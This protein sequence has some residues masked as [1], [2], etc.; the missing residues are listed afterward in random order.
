MVYGTLK[1]IFLKNVSIY[2]TNLDKINESCFLVPNV[3]FEVYAPSFLERFFESHAVMFQGN[4]G[5]KP[6]EGEITSRPWQWP[7][8]YR[9][10]D[11]MQ[12]SEVVLNIDIS[13]TILFWFQ[14][15]GLSIRKSSNLVGQ[16][17]I[18]PSFRF[19]FWS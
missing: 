1:K 4:A 9:V 18:S 6:K 7:I 10:G 8:N 11:F 16:F 3:S 15:Q 5:L 2:Q 19:C 12:L 17:N 14:L 13:G